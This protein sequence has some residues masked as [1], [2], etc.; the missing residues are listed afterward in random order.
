MPSREQWWCYVLLESSIESI[1]LKTPWLR[2]LTMGAITNLRCAEHIVITVPGSIGSA[3]D[4]W[5]IQRVVKPASGNTHRLLV[6]TKS[7]QLDWHFAF[8]EVLEGTSPYRLS[9]QIRG[10]V[11][12]DD[13][14]CWSIVLK[15]VDVTTQWSCA[16]HSPCMRSCQSKELRLSVENL[17]AC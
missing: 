8:A 3:V 13:I 2:K 11:R 16:V 4:T 15:V 14:Q 9:V 7:G 17:Q 1:I 12:I 5:I 10:A 6:A